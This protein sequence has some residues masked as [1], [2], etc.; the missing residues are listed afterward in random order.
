MNTKLSSFSGKQIFIGLAVVIV[1]LLLVLAAISGKSPTQE[2]SPSSQSE[3]QSSYP[4]TQETN[5]VY[6]NQTQGF[7]LN[8]PPQ[9]MVKNIS[10]DIVSVSSYDAPADPDAPATGMQIGIFSGNK[11]ADNIDLAKDLFKTPL[12]KDI[13]VNGVAAKELSGYGQGMLEG[14]F[15]I[16]V[17]IYQDGKTYELSY[18]EGEPDFSKEDFEQILASFKFTK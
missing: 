13:V 16:F 17:E 18:F 4:T 14:K 9:I 10:S 2:D 6:T 8:H 7:Q 11:V 15:I 12:I 5:G 3:G 1:V